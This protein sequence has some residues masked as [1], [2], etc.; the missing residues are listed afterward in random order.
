M[1]E[2]TIKPIVQVA[3]WIIAAILVYLN[4]QLLYSEASGYFSAPDSSV[5][6]KIMIIAGGIFL[7]FLLLYTL[8]YPLVKKKIISSSINV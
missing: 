2:F 1:G 5:T 7:L 3:A 6:G 8:I 4:I